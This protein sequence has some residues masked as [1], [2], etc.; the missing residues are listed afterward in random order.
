M[1]SILSSLASYDEMIKEEILIKLKGIRGE[2]KEE[3]KYT[4][5]II[6][7]GVN[8]EMK[9]LEN[10]KLEMFNKL[11]ERT[12]FTWDNN[13]NIVLEYMKN[14]KGKFPKKESLINRGS[15]WSDQK[16]ILQRG[17]LIQERKLK[18]DRYKLLDKKLWNTKEEQ[19]GK[20]SKE[21]LDNKW[22]D[23][24]NIVLKYVNT[25]NG[26]IP[27]TTDSKNKGDWLSQQKNHYKDGILSEDRKEK[28][29]ENELIES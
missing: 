12:M 9:D 29:D 18:I 25:H 3:K 4:E 19:K 28:I 26:E 7:N 22:D 11:G 13:L 20:H 6:I 17:E 8:L 27:G 2:L 5:R 16:K 24:F 10:I 23:Y 1:K 14:N 21:N 15:W